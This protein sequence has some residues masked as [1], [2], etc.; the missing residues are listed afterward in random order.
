MGKIW[1]FHLKNRLVG[2][3]G[4]TNIKIVSVLIIEIP[5]LTLIMNG[6]DGTNSC[7]IL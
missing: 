2:I 4:N 5:P 1:P 6:R 3:K 7:F